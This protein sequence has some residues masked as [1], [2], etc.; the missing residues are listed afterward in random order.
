M[1]A[2]IQSKAYSKDQP[3][4]EKDRPS[5]GDCVKQH[6][7]DLNGPQT[8]LLGS[9]ELNSV[10]LNSNETNPGLSDA[11]L[12]TTDIKALPPQA[13]EILN[14]PDPRAVLVFSGKRKSGKDYVTEMI[15]SRLGGDTC[16]ILRLSAPLKLQYA[17]VTANNHLDFI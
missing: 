8:N 16:A 13:T 15:R 9:L 1:V 17:K 5:G 4:S 7:K 2:R 6:S 10:V 3:R 14:S 11:Q 12:G